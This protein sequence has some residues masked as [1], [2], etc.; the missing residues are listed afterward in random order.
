MIIIS[1]DK[2]IHMA[3]RGHSSSNKKPNTNSPIQ[4]LMEQPV[5]DMKQ[6]DSLS[7]NS[8]PQKKK[9]NLGQN[10]IIFKQSLTLSAFSI[11][12]PLPTS[13]EYVGAFMPPI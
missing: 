5:I 8:P 7:S 1:D 3:N 2:S 4:V 11:S 10:P 9:K 13:S 6:Y 12:L